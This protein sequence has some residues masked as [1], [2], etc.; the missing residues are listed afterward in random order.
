MTVE[1]SSF[2]DNAGF[3]F[4][5]DGRLYRQINEPYRR[6]WEALLASGLLEDLQADGQLISHSVESAH[7]VPDVVGRLLPEQIPLITYPYEWCFSQL[8]D[9]A[10]L[11]LEIQKRALARGFSL[12]DA[13]AYNVQF[14]RAKP[15]F[16]DTLSFEEYEEGKAWVGYRQFCRHFLAPLAL[17]AKVHPD[18]GRM[19]AA[20]IDGLPLDLASQALPAVTKF[21]SGL[22][23]HLHLHSRAESRPGEGSAKSAHVSKTGLLGLID[24][25]ERTV[26]GLD[27]KPE[28][29]VWA[30]YYQATNYSDS[31][32]ASKAKIVR[33]FLS[34]T[35]QSED[36]VWDLG[37]NTG[38]FSA[39][40]AELGARVASWDIDPA[41]VERHYRTVRSQ[42][43][44]NVLPLVQDLTQPSPG[45]GWANEER[46]SFAERSDAVAVMALAL[47]H[48]LAIGSNIPL[49]RVAEVFSRLAAAAIV[50]FVP[51]SDSQ[52]MRLLASRDDIFDDYSE[53]GFLNAFGQHFEVRASERVSES[54]RTIYLLDRK[55]GR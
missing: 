24:S 33:R 18:F 12:K 10:L 6:T 22:A 21:N 40:A 7:G 35:I 53:E 27:W 4:W 36:S 46:R 49:S 47:I 25:L 9:A 30:D 2:R 55:G 26:Q 34:E 39:I 31:A 43:H 17:I 41:A 32:M 29:T 20:H 19:A 48:H 28:G 1:T 54:D 37:A 16:I 15:V 50:E 44:A 23:I 8:K 52:V 13:S 14:L 3:V 51:K 38:M 42:E 5:E 11:T 45:I